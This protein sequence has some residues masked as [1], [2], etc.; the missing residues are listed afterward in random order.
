MLVRNKEAKMPRWRVEQGK[1]N[2]VKHA[3]HS[4]NYPNGIF[5]TILEADDTIGV[6]LIINGYL[7]KCKSVAAAKVEAKDRLKTN[8]GIYL[9][10]SN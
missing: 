6:T 2:G 3:V 4:C 9:Q 10:S 1:T 7:F 8:R 5:S